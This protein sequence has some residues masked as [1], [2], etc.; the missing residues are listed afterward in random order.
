MAGTRLHRAAQTIWEQCGAS[1][2][3]LHDVTILVP[4]FHAVAELNQA[5]L[6]ASNQSVLLVPK[7]VTFPVWATGMPTGHRVMPQSRRTVL[8]YHTIKQRGWFD[9]ALLWAMCDEIGHLF[10]ELTHQAVIL[11]SDKEE[12]AEQLLAYYQTQSHT[13]VEFE[14]RVVHELWFALSTNDLAQDELSPSALYALQ[15][16]QLAQTATTPLFVVSMPKLTRL[17]RNCLERYA[18]RQPVTYVAASEEND[19]SR[20]LHAAWPQDLQRPLAIR[21]REC[22]EY[23]P[24]SPLSDRIGF[25]GARSLEE[26]ATIADIQVRTWLAEGKQSIALIVQDRMSARRLRA[27]LERAQ[28]LVADET[29][30]TLD[31]TQA[32]TIVMR[33]LEALSADFPYQDVIDLV[34]SGYVLSDWDGEQREAA[35]RQIEQVLRSTGPVQGCASLLTALQ[36]RDGTDEAKAAVSHL[37]RCATRVRER[38]CPLDRW[39]EQLES[40]LADLGALPLLAADTAGAQLLA[41]ISRLRQELSGSESRLDLAEFH[42]WLDRELESGV[43]IDSAI[44]SPVVFT[45]LAATR[46]RHFDAAMI[47]GADAAH[48][49]SLSAHSVFFNQAVRFSLG[50]AIHADEIAQIQDDVLQLVSHTDT[51]S[52]VWRTSRDGEIN[53]ISPWMERLDSLHRLAWGTSLIDDGWRS[54]IAPLQIASH[55]TLALPAVDRMPRVILPSQLIPDEIS[56]TGYNTLI[57]CPYQ[58]YA[59]H[60]LGLDEPD[61]I[62]AEMEK[63]DYGQTVHQILHGFHATHPK[64]GDVPVD[65]LIDDLAAISLKTFAPGLEQDFY[66]HAWQQKWL[67][68]LPLYIEWQIER[69]QNGWFWHDGELAQRREFTLDQARTIALYGRLDRI[70][71][72]NGVYAV[73]DYKTGNQQG[74]KNKLKHIDEDMQLPAY[75]LLLQASVVQAAFVSLDGDGIATIGLADDV[76]ADATDRCAERLL[77]LFGQMHG[78]VPLPANGVDEVCQHCSVRGLCRRDHWEA[79]DN[80]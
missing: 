8:L 4:N 9:P 69:E 33:W 5:L 68:K 31:T 30:W 36:C 13:A 73:L 70:D 72:K 79:A 66:V 27:M 24:H 16:A 26:E 53:A 28:I 59:R 71:K 78:K 22:A 21:A 17:E 47:L 43:F 37:Q 2:T 50:L 29:G 51:V 12:F 62:S 7:T 38:L 46:L 52:M 77:E 19:R 54:R 39:L 14:A 15:L 45:H 74:L 34:K 76:I 3:V 49:P 10:D 42:R 44:V 25:F 40:S 57:A 60:L 63:S 6:I 41:L 11:P 61:E 65:V 58:Y 1:Q 20:I 48:L 35:V 80:E 23:F 56:V 64:L 18:E 75:A 32:S 67:A 55:D